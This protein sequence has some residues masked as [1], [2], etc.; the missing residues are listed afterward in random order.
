NVQKIPKIKLIGWIVIDN[1]VMIK[2]IK[3]TNNSIIKLVLI[4]LIKNPN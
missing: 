3:T 2:Y 4:L 1:R